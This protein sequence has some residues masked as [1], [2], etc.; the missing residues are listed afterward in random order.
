MPRKRAAA[1]IPPRII[2]RGLRLSCI[3]GIDAAEKDIAQRVLVD[4]D[5]TPATAQTS[6]LPTIDY[7]AVVRRL[8]EFAAAKSHGLLETFAEEAAELVLAEFTAVEIR[9][10]CRKPSPFADLEEAGV[11]IVRKR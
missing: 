9:L 1:K 10:Y 3:I 5:I 11:E 6:D 8:R 4:A 7:A 2:L